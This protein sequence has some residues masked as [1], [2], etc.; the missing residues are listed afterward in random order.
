MM[1]QGQQKEG[2]AQQAL[3]SA[4]RNS[5]MS[6]PGVEGKSIK[7]KEKQQPK[8]EGVFQEGESGQRCQLQVR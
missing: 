1:G 8:S 2:K 4:L 7:K 3:E 5:S 6:G